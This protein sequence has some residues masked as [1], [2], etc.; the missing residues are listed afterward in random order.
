MLTLALQEGRKQQEAFSSN[1]IT[2][3]GQTYQGTEGRKEYAVI[4]REREEKES[5]TEL[6]KIN[7]G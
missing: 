2:K 7:E 5:S 4:E 3:S 6:L 1:L